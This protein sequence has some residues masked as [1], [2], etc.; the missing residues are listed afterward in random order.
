M[1]FLTSRIQITTVK[2]IKYNHIPQGLV[3]RLSSYT[4][5]FVGKIYSVPEE[6]IFPIPLN[7]AEQLW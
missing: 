4:G 1:L 6:S 3:E 7:S 5:I 2:A